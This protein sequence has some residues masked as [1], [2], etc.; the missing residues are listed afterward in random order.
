VYRKDVGRSGQ[1]N[2]IRPKIY[3]TW[4]RMRHRCLGESKDA[5]YYRDRGIT[6]CDEW[7]DNYDAFRTWA[8]ACGVTRELTLDRIDNDGPYSP[9]NCRWI[10]QSE[11]NYNKRYFGEYLPGCTGDSDRG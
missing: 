3:N 9:A 10:T 6:I 8:I 7:R 5:R 11:Q 2:H 1:P 4:L